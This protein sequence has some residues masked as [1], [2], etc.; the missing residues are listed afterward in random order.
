MKTIESQR[1]IINIKSRWVD[2]R[3]SRM[4]QKN[5][6]L[7]IEK[8]DNGYSAF[9]PDFPGCVSAAATK[10]ETVSLFNEAIKLHVEGLRENG[11]Q[12]IS[13]GAFVER[14]ES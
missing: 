12:T 8:T 2:K 9:A 14:F 10:E 6:T 5:H 3:V 1:D 4:N 7:I 11:Q 13:P